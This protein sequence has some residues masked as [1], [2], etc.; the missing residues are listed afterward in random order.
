[1]HFIDPARRLIQQTGKA[2][3]GDCIFTIELDSTVEVRNCSVEML[4]L[5]LGGSGRR[6]WLRVAVI[7]QSLPRLAVVTRRFWHWF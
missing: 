3:L 6:G 5:L 7:A 4:D 1:M 2:E